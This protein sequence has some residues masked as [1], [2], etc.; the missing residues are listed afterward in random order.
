[1]AKKHVIPEDVGRTVLLW[2]VGGALAFAAAAY[3]LTSHIQ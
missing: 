2:T 3:F 1:M